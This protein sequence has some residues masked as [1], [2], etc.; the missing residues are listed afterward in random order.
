MDQGSPLVCRFLVSVSVGA[1]APSEV[2]DKVAPLYRAYNHGRF[3]YLY[4]HDRNLFNK[5]RGDRE[6]TAIGKVLPYA[7]YKENQ[8]TIDRLC[9]DLAVVYDLYSEEKHKQVLSLDEVVK[10]YHSHGQLMMVAKE[11][12]YCGATK[13]VYRLDS[14][15]SLKTT[16]FTDIKVEYER[17][18]AQNALYKNGE[19]K[20]VV[21][22]VW[23]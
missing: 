22:Y 12:G 2:L 17:T 13:P 16:I 14:V 9:P 23:A 4:Q 8:E 7:A 5:Q 21:F 20:G 19:D 3:E 6:E 15:A 10:G 18:K 11:E 1:K